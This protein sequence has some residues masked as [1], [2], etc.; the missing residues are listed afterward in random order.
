MRRRT[1]SET[2][3]QVIERML[4]AYRLKSG[5]TE[6]NLKSEWESIVGPVISSRTD[7]ILLR[8]PKLILKINSAAMKQELHYQR[9]EIMQNVNK[10]LGQELIKEVLVQ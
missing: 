7:D 3:D 6:L 8:G 5:L 10:H 9:E 1:N 4:K 2:L